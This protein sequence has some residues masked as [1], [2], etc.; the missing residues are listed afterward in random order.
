MILKMQSLPCLT[1][2]DFS[3]MSAARMR[4][5]FTRVD[6]REVWGVGR[7]TGDKVPAMGIGTVHALRDAPL[8]DMRA[9]FGAVMD[10]TC[11]ELSGA[12]CLALQEVVPP[13]QE[14]VSSRSFGAVHVFIHTNQFH[15]GDPQ[16]SNCVTVSLFEEP[17]AGQSRAAGGRLYSKKDSCTRRPASCR[18]IWVRTRPGKNRCSRP[19]CHLNPCFLDV[20]GLFNNVE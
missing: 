18:W 7:R 13:R 3:T 17:D 2:C 14:I 1:A 6:V 15:Q 16:Y 20:L 10:R 19:P 12:S 4:W 11:N 9:R 8:R 5:L